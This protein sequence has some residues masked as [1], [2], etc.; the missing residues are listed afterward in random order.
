MLLCLLLSIYGLLMVGCCF[1]LFEFVLFVYLF[2][3]NVIIIFYGFTEDLDIT[4]T[5]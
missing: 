5:I 1:N 4:V 3:F 2:L